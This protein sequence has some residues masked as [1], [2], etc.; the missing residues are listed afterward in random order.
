[1]VLQIKNTIKPPSIK[2]LGRSF[3]WGE[4]LE[5]RK[6][7]IPGFD[8]LWDEPPIHACGCWDG[9]GTDKLMF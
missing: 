2:G 4:F 9:G 5:S 3:N 1:M 6:A 8:D 7:S